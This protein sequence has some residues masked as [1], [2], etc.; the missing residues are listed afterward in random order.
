MLDLIGFLGGEQPRKEQQPRAVKLTTD[1]GK[2]SFSES[3]K[4]P[5]YQVELKL[6]DDAPGK[7][8]NDPKAALFLDRVEYYV[9]N[10]TELVG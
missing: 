10:P 3:K 2:L 5:Q 7:I 1:D 4:G 6:A 8:L 9:R